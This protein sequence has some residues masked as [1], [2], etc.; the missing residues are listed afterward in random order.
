VFRTGFEDIRVGDVVTSLGR[1]IDT[2][3]LLAYSMLSGDWAAH[4]IDAEYTA[5]TRFRGRIAHGTIPLAAVF[6]LLRLPPG[7]TWKLIY[8][9]RS[10]RWIAPVRIGDTIRGRLQVKGKV[11]G[12]GPTG[13][14]DLGFSVLNQGDDK[15]IVAPLKAEVARG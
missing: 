2:A 11:D 8:G 9:L 1:T 12:E 10:V 6:G 4:H 15:V 3:D 14:L 13:T 7:S 5:R